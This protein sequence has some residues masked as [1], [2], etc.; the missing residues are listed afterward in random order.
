[1]A[2]PS[3]RL[4]VLFLGLAAAGRIRAQVST[5]EL[6]GAVADPSGAAVS[7][8]RVVATNAGTGVTREAS[9]DASGRYLFTLLPP[10]TYEL[11]VEAQG[12][13]R[14]VQSGLVLEV[15]Q[16]AQVDLTLQVGSVSETIQVSAAPPLLES[17][18][19]SLGSVIAERFVNE[20]PLNGR[21]FVQL[22][23]LSP[24]VSGVGYNTTGTIMSGSR[25]DDRRPGTEVF[26]NG[27]R[28][29]SNNFLYDGA[30]NNDRYTL[31]IVLRPAIEAVR[32]FKV[33]TNLYSAD[34]GR[35]SGAVVDVVTK[36]GSN[37]W[38]GSVFEFLRNSAMDARNYFNVRGTPFPSFQLNQ[39]GVSLGGP[40]TIPGLYKGRNRTFFFVDYEGYRRGS[41]NSFQTTV[42][43]DTIRRG[44]FTGENRIFD[45]LST[46]PNPAGAGFIR[47][48]FAGNQIP[49]SRFDPVTLKLVNAYPAPQNAGRFNN[50]LVN[51]TL[52]QNWDQGDVRVDHQISQKDTFF[53]RW[54]IQHT[55][56]VT[57]S[58]FPD[59]RIQGLSKPVGL[60]NE[61]SFSGSAFQPVQHAV[62]NWVH[63][64]TPRLINEFRAG[65]NRFVM[66]YTADGFEAG[67]TLGNQLG[68]PNSNTSQ[69]QSVLPVISPANYAGAGA[70]RTQP[71][72]RI[73]N[74]F[75]YTD[76]VTFT[77]GSHTLKFGGDFRRRQLTD[78]GV[79]RGTGRYNFNPA[80]TNL[81]GVA[82]TGNTMA[83]MLLGY[84]TL[85]EKDWL[86]AWVG[87]RGIEPG[88]YFADD[89]R[90]TRK[91]T[92]NLGLRWE[93]Y[94]PFVEVADRWS[95]FD[96]DTA[97]MKLAGR[98]GVDRRVNV[99][100]DFRNFAPRFGFAYQVLPRTVV[101]GGYGIF[102]N[103]GGALNGALR[104]HRNLPFGPVYSI[105][106]G[107]INVGQR[108]S[109]GFP[110]EP[111]LDLG[112]AR[113][114]TGSVIGIFPGFRSSYA[115]Q[116][117]L[118]VQQE[119]PQLRTLFKLAFVGNLGRRLA[120]NLDINQPVPGPTAVASRRP[121]FAVRPALAGITYA[122]S[123]GLSSYNSFQLS[124]ERRMSRGLGVMLGYTWGHIIENVGTEYGGGTGAPQDIRN[125]RADRGNAPFDL[126]HRLTLS[127]LYDLPFGKGRPLVNRGGVA[128]FVIGG[129][130]TNGIISLQ[131]G[132]P[133]TPMLQT[134]TTNCC[135]SRPDRRAAGTLPAGEQ[136]R[137]RWFDPAAFTTPALYTFGNAGR[138]ILYGPG[139]VNFDVSLFK[140]FRIREEVK[141]QFR[142][143]GFNVFNTPQ[144]G[145]PNASIGNVQAGVISSTVGNPRQ[146]QLALR[147][148]F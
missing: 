122:L 52:R 3:V 70:T 108:A 39:F 88:L 17:Q 34:L 22:A 4:A 105:A 74:T 130:Q 82:A 103:P 40:M 64:F 11:S 44:D 120:T 18:S 76:N 73:I 23:I 30:D 50:Y 66:N 33:Q 106:P 135:A 128:D 123:D 147:F 138:N 61:D 136:T 121:Y 102:Y 37:E 20:L 143:E 132:L 8:A 89:Y 124:V 75:H 81:P 31:S 131:T 140:D 67:G 24:G 90:V 69:L 68:I 79:N 112:L 60:N 55:E 134:P 46:R 96:A 56:T 125:R 144:F 110:A 6:A 80:F 141:F 118:T 142:A 36:S 84:P 71:I 47:D 109:D 53:A 65:F 104:G 92:L 54:S 10:G 77:A 78:Y 62:A 115:Q 13:R 87:V 19:S 91:L 83:S 63:I 117:N 57:P 113:N 38:H 16:R 9:S 99:R 28:E 146:L 85:I 129:W 119:V 127:Y 58:T 48:Q 32:E 7:G 148:Q 2:S 15:N 21:N 72:L 26:S 139:R 100:R 101:R 41:L 114:P 49:A 43:T 27:N 97:V 51:S 1:M 98:D 137:V 35:N 5:A 94:S 93:Y 126:R 145:L 29:G 45:P 95:F 12:F 86:L 111:Q 25:P 59:I 14:V 107:D 116:Y 133:Y 42:P